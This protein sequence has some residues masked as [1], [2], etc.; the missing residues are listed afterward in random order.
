MRLLVVATYRDT[1][2]AAGD[3]FGDFLADVPRL[4]GTER[5]PLTGLDAVG[6]AAFVEAAAGHG[7]DEDG[8]ALADVV[9]R[10]TEGNCFFVAEVLRHLAESGALQE[11]QGRWSATATVA[12]LPIPDGVRA[13][14]ARRLSRLPQGTR[15][16]LD[17]AAV[18]GLEF[19]PT[20]VRAA[21]DFAED[22]VLSALDAAIAARLVVDI[23]GP[24]PRDRFT[25]ALVR[26]TVYDG[27][28]AARRQALHRR[29][30]EAIEV[31]QR[32][33]LDDH[34][35]ALA[36]HWGQ[37][38]VSDKAADYA[39][40]AGDRAA[41][42]LA[43]D[44]AGIFYR[45]ARRLVGEGDPRWLELLI[46]E[47]EARRQAGD[48]GYR[49]LLLDAARRAQ[50]IGDA[51]SLVRAALANTRG[52][53][54]T[55]AGTID[56]RR[57][58]MLEAAVAATGSEAT[59]RRA[60]LLAALALEL[61]WESDRRR[62]V[63]YSDEALALARRL[64]EPATLVAVL[65]RR[66]VAVSAP[67]NVAERWE[68]TAELVT[69]AEGLGDPMAIGWS[70]WL[71]TRVALEVADGPETVRALRHLEATAA[72]LGQPFLSWFTSMIRG[73]HAIATGR[74][75]EAERLLDQTRALGDITGQLDRTFFAACQQW[76]LRFE[77][78][79]LDE[80]DEQQFTRDVV[81]SVDGASPGGSGA[82]RLCFTY[83]AAHSAEL[84]RT[85][86]AREKFEVLARHDFSDFPVD[87]VWLMNL[88]MISAVAA[89]LG[90]V[91]RSGLLY[92]R[93]LP[94]ADQ[95][96]AGGGA[97][98]GA[99]AWYLGRLATTLGKPDTAIGHYGTAEAVN[100]R[101]GARPWL[102]RTH[103]E[104]GRVLIARDDT[105]DA[106]M[107]REL[108]GRALTA[109]VALGLPVVE[110]HARTALETLR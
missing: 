13:V 34:L 77:L 53:Y 75:D 95:V 88:A 62:R 102:A 40:R 70:W 101:A 19:D 35:P 110:R 4:D 5:V 82:Q 26:S 108:L 64:D 46:A 16:L 51:G 81:Y 84:G 78:G 31:I 3:P 30:A 96:A 38:G 41:A 68:H 42:Q 9:W 106:T 8:A 74:L 18:A 52:M 94:Y 25:H 58:A 100:A 48:S 28:S 36:H 79:R 104:W 107:A 73:N 12:S 65:G 33:H 2:T 17:T 37:A 39:E 56:E 50:A 80:M 29:T 43:H 49:A 109:A 14:V 67:A 54:P 10:E 90:D 21:G 27:L 103:L 63:A 91:R 60:V 22:D 69:L 66:I 47:G 92:E 15:R 23:P 45:Q 32:N 24:V 83:L 97:Y 72:D 86:K 59:P 55:A 61:T 57:V 85:D 87:A 89:Y 6:V 71:R 11:R 7:L 98:F 105:G 99:V 44:E 1:E 20:L 76:L 93:L